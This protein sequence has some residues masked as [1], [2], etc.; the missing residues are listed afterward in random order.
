MKLA[1][2]KQLSFVAGE[3]RKV[4]KMLAAGG[5]AGIQLKIKE[6]T[7]ELHYTVKGTP[8]NWKL[9]KKNPSDISIDCFDAEGYDDGMIN[10]SGNKVFS[11]VSVD[12]NQ[13]REAIGENIDYLS[14]DEDFLEELENGFDID[15]YLSGSDFTN[16]IF[17]GWVRGKL[18]EGSEID[19]NG[20]AE[21]YF[22]INETQWAHEY[23]VT[24]TGTLSK[25]GEYWYE[26]VFEWT[27][28]ETDEDGEP[29]DPEIEHEFHYD[30]CVENYGCR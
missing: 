30:E 22:D 13:I 7:G 1:N 24:I 3:L 23:D 6:M 25:N 29:L 11:K 2:D 10:V 20:N 14:D 21:I 15:V 19:F 27:C 16:V 9:E 8:E 4:A 26:D 18:T 12:E 17:G 5:G 28:P